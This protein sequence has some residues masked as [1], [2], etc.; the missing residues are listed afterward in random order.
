MPAASASAE[1]CDVDKNI[2]E[3]LLDAADE[4]ITP[5]VIDLEVWA[6]EPRRAMHR[7]LWVWRKR[8]WVSWGPI[9]SPAMKSNRSSAAC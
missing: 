5:D 2:A 3:P 1:R 6:W 7:W 8:E 4:M 9:P